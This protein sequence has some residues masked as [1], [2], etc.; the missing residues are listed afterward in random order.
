MLIILKRKNFKIY[1]G[2]KWC[3]KRTFR[4]NFMTINTVAS[5][6]VMPSK[7]FAINFERFM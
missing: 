4:R 3:I 1:T 5:A 6:V 7:K 2:Q